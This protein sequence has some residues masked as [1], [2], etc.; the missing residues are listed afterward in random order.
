MMHSIVI[1]LDE[2]LWIAWSI[3]ATL[4][5]FIVFKIKINKW[6][7]EHLVD[8]K[9]GEVTFLVHQEFHMVS[10]SSN[11]LQEASSPVV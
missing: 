8:I 7:M 2:P 6:P 4:V 9:G 11:Q 5:Y 10:S 3:P 1:Q